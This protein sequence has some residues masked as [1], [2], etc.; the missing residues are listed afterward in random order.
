M[1][2]SELP[3]TSLNVESVIIEVKVYPKPVLDELEISYS[4]QVSYIRVYGLSGKLL[5]TQITSSKVDLSF[6]QSG[7]YVVAVVVQEAS[8]RFKMIK[9]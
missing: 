7:R 2:F 5:F 8:K 9:E 1:G 3:V 6:L 4:Q